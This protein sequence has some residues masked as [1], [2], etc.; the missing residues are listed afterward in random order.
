MVYEL[1]RLAMCCIALY[2]MVF[3]L[4]QLYVL[5]S[6]Y[7]M[8]IYLLQL[9]ICCLFLY[10]TGLF[11][12]ALLPFALYPMGFWFASSRCRHSPLWYGRFLHN[13]LLAAILCRS[14]LYTIINYI[15]VF[16]AFPLCYGSLHL[17]SQLMLSVI[18]YLSLTIKLAVCCLSRYAMGHSAFTI[19]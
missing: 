19:S 2:P 6:L 10:P 12:A 3:E 13:W 15:H 1:P 16:G 18:R 17:H 11:T 14:A 4:S 9:A 7:P 5:H 8:V